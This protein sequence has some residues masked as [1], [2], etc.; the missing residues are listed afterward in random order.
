MSRQKDSANYDAKRVSANALNIQR[1]FSSKVG[2]VLNV[3]VC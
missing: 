2:S 3:A 1:A